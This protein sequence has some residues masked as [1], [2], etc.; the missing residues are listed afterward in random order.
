MPATMQRPIVFK[1]LPACEYLSRY[2]I[3]QTAVNTEDGIELGRITFDANREPEFQGCTWE[4]LVAVAKHMRE[5][6][7]GID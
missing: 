3:T 4:Q 6:A 1:Q 2:G 7:N 5:R